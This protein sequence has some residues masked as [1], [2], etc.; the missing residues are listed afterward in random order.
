MW[1]RV[2][3]KFKGTHSFKYICYLKNIYALKLSQLKYHYTLCAIRSF[4]DE[5]L[6]EIASG[7]EIGTPYGE[8]GVG[9]CIKIDDNGE[10][11]IAESCIGKRW[12]LK[13]GFVTIRK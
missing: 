6:V 5:I 4:L 1:V 12:M 8:T 11:E 10:R 9:V 13:W 2:Q 3:F 7:E